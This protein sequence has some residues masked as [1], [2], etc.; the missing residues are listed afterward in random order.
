MADPPEYG[1]KRRTDDNVIVTHNRNATMS[2][3]A[4]R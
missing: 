3:L 4:K 2:S 1:T